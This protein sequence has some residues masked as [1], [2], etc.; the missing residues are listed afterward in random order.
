MTGQPDRARVSLFL[1][2]QQPL[3]SDQIRA[4]DGQLSLVEEVRNH[5][6][7]GVIVGQHHLSDGLTQMQPAPFLGRISAVAGDMSLGVGI[8]LLPLHNPVHVAETYATLDVLSHGRL[9]FGVGLGYRKVEYAAFGVDPKTKISR[10]DANLRIVRSL[11]AGESVTCDYPWCRLVEQQLSLVP[12]Q[13]P[14]PPIWMAANSDRA[15][16]RAARL[17]DTWMINPHADFETVERQIGLFESERFAAGRAAKPLELPLMREVFCA[18]TR[19]DAVAMAGPY[20]SEKYRTYARWGQDDVLPGNED[21]TRPLD[22][23]I[24]NRFILGTPDDCATALLRWKQGYGVN[25]FVIRTDWAGMP[26]E[27]STQSIR[28]LSDEVLPLL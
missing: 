28:L 20:L 26:P 16:R 27:V 6:W 21:F 23:L 15:V 17:A 7:D 25:H 19:A 5:G 1:T 12:V 2:N 22:K 13:R 8:N 10:L 3:G 14:G 9:I 24:E 18:P 4:L 11:W